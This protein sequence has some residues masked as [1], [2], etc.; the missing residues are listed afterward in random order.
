MIKNPFIGK[1]TNFI[2]VYSVLIFTF[3]ISS[4][5]FLWVVM[6]SFKTNLAILSNPF[7][8]PK[9]LNFHVYYQ[10]LTQYKLIAYFWHSVVISFSATF[11]ALF[12][13]TLAAYVFAKYDFKG[14]NLLY[15]VLV[16]TLLIPGFTKV[17]PIFALI[18]FL[19]LI[20]TKLGLILVYSSNGLALA[21]FIMRAA[22]MTNPKQIDEAALIDGASFWKVFWA[23]NVPLVRPGLSTAGILLF[24]GSWNEYFY[25][26]VLT[27]SASNRTLPLSVA[28]FNEAFSYNYTLL[29]AALTIV[30]L[31]SII[32]YLIVQEQVQQSVA[33]AGVKG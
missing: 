20:D 13:Y 14:K 18:N 29:F 21:L 19:H 12:F 1:T 31:P 17:Q 28:F 16:I 4:L 15:T 22:F 23:V 10:V 5:P 27:S 3:L 6:S 2:F 24:L 33:S 11:I 32:L 9:S 7:Q 26:L 30:V 25:A 8:L